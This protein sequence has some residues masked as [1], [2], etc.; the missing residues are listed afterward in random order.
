M[1]NRIKELRKKKKLTQTQLGLMID[2]SKQQIG[3]LENGQSDLTD[4]WMKRIAA[5]LNCEP[6]ELL[7]ADGRGLYQQERTLRYSMPNRIRELRDKKL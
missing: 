6:W 5:V 7:H 2:S 3:R 4:A 1:S